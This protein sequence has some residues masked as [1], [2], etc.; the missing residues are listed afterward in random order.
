MK[1]TCNWKLQILFSLIKIKK[2]K[3]NKPAFVLC[4]SAALG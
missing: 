3:K 4:L 1:V 2:K